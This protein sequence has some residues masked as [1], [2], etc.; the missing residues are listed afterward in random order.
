MGKGKKE[1]KHRSCRVKLSGS[2]R[3]VVLTIMRWDGQAS[4]H[5]MI[6]GQTPCAWV[7]RMWYNKACTHYCKLACTLSYSIPPL[8]PSH[9]AE[10]ATQQ[11]SLGSES[12]A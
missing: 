6:V 11:L 8:S 9:R 12:E 4:G 10:A 5:Q 7:G 3:L 2:W 1:A